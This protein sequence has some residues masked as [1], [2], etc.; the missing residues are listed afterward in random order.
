MPNNSILTLSVTRGGHAP[1]TFQKI[2][3]LC[4]ERQYTKQNSVICLRLNIL[5]SPKIWG[6]LCYWFLHLF[7]FSDSWFSGWC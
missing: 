7:C 2:V 6:W 4:F 5:V 3:S 1:Q